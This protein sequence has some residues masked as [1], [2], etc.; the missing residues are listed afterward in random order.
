MTIESPEEPDQ[1]S[2]AA[3]KSANAVVLLTK[4]LF[5][6]THELHTK[7]ERSGIINDVLR[8]RAT[9]YGYALLLRNLLPAYQ[10]L[11]AGLE[12][13]RNSPLVGALARREVYR[14]KAIIS[15][16]VALFG[17]SWE[18]ALP[19]LPPGEQY[20]QRIASAERGDGANLVAHAYTRYLGDL[21]GGQV[22]KRLLARTP[23]LRPGEMSFYDFPNID[24]T[25]RFKQLYRQA[26]NDS[27][28]WMTNMDAVIA[29]AIEAFELNIAV[30][31]LVQKASTVPA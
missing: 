21:S 16:L 11:E 22:L 12:A 19:L 31:Q 5:E 14:T 15:D 30:S 7:A 18:S 13:N 26:I 2:A 17:P 27:A 29:E 8:G 24:D 1:N 4:V 25:N 28:A 10:Q 6:R 9:K 23:G 3:T 20:A